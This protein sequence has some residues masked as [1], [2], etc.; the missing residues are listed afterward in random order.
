MSKSSRLSFA[1][2]RAS[3]RRQVVGVAE[4]GKL[5]AGPSIAVA[6][7]CGR[8]G[9]RTTDPGLA[10]SLPTHRPVVATPPFCWQSQATVYEASHSVAESG[11]ERR[12]TMTVQHYFAVKIAGPAARQ[13]FRK[14]LSWSLPPSFLSLGENLRQTS[15]SP[16]FYRRKQDLTNRPGLLICKITTKCVVL[17]RYSSKS[18]GSRLL[19]VLVANAPGARPSGRLPANFLF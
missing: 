15:L 16:V 11:P 1:K 18:L 4:R 10:G 14:V 2:H 6:C 7:G 8:A 9:L 19:S 17:E 5:R 3:C 12:G 13:L